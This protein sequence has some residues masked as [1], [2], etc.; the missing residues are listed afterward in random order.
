[1]ISVIEHLDERKE[2]IMEENDIIYV[3]QQLVNVTTEVVSSSY[4]ESAGSSL[5]LD[6]DSWHT[7]HPAVHPPKQ[8]G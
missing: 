4:Y 2:N 7:A 1:M 6:E 3:Y 5:I 8:V